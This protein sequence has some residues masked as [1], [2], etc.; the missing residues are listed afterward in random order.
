[1]NEL[2]ICA[3]PT[4]PLP[5]RA[6]AVLVDK[7]A[8]WTSFDVIRKLRGVVRKTRMGH[9]GTLDPMAT[10]LL[11]V[12]LNK[13]TKSMDRFMRLDKRYEGTIRLG[14]TTASYD[15]ETPVLQQTDASHVTL[16]A[17][18]QACE[19]LTGSIS[20]VPP[21]YSAVKVKGERL[22][23]KARRGETVPR[24]PNQVSVFRFEIR[25]RV[26]DD[27][28]FEVHC[29]KGTYIRTLA[30]DLGQLL[31]V[32]AHLVALRR[33]AI[34]SYAVKDAWPLME[35]VKAAAPARVHSRTP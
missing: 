28:L 32:G 10:G 17:I 20:Q 9:T 30:H 18:E 27:L 4:I 35:L 14:Q 11:I 26:D 15:A 13:G 2:Q 23:K 7:P 12:L 33:T 24:E 25:Q 8:G 29:S 6:A 31:E 1:M 16:S 3:H 19:G 34:G 22:Y 5:G 21:M